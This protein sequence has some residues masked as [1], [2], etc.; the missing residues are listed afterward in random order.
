M[1]STL[2]NTPAGL[3]VPENI[4]NFHVQLS[5]P[6]DQDVKVTVSLDKAKAAEYDETAETLDADA[7]TLLTSEVTIPAGK[8][9]STEEIV[10]EINGE[11]LRN[12]PWRPLS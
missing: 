7:L 10:V 3:I 9:I 11:A 5:K 4:L 1:Q 12:T 8:T 2:V 6:V